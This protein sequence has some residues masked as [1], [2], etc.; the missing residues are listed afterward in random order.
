MSSLLGT[1]YIFNNLCYK[2]L[3]TTAIEVKIYCCAGSYEIIQTY[4]KEV[5]MLY[6]KLLYKHIRK[7]INTYFSIKRFENFACFLTLVNFNGHRKFIGKLKQLKSLLRKSK[8]EGYRGRSV[9]AGYN[10]TRSTP[11]VMISISFCNHQ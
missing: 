6:K 1:K 2:R 4:A 8:S 3:I 10:W 5:L 11:S 9:L 7:N